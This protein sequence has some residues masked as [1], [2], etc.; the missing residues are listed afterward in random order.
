MPS[1]DV[2]EYD[3]WGAHYRIVE[4]KNKEEIYQSCAL[5]GYTRSHVEIFKRLKGD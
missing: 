4:A 2:Y 3:I 5:N 1:Y